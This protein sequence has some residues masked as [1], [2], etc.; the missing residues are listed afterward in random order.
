MCIKKNEVRR[1]YRP[2]TMMHFLNIDSS[3]TGLNLFAENW[4]Q[5]V[6]QYMS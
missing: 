6:K 1:I 5:N 4:A 2:K 3:W